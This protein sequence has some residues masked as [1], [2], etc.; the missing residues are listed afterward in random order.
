MSE[1]DIKERQKLEDKIKLLDRNVILSQKMKSNL[2]NIKEKIN[3]NNEDIKNTDNQENPSRYG[4]N[5]IVNATEI[6]TY[7]GT[8]KT[9]QIAK[10]T[11]KNTT[12]TIKAVIDTIKA[13]A[14]GTKSTISLI[15]AGGWIL[16][17]VIIV[18]CMVGAFVGYFTSDDAGKELPKI[19]QVAKIEV[20][21]D[22]TGGEKYWRWYGF[23]ERVE[24]CAVFVSWCANESNCIKEDK[25]PKY[26]V[27]DDGINWFKEKGEWQDKE[28]YIPKPGD[29]I[30]FNW[31]E[32]NG[33]RDE[34]SDHTGIVEKI[35]IENKKV[36]TIEGNSS[37]N[38][39]RRSYNLN[40]E[41][42]VGYG[43]PNY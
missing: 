16:V 28:N 39:K 31:L 24:W 21:E 23:Q 9:Y 17:V 8:K 33:T 27:C 18:F 40:S 42:I 30:F 43:T 35:D 11:A 5:K 32:D 13:I 41:D 12:K 38:C 7:K 36:N 22:K 10:T 6:V 4:I 19:L 3:E 20:E 15:V 25:L 2:V 26:S 37:D 1:I 34:K 29:I 14:I